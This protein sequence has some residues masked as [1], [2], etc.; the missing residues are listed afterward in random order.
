[1]RNLVEIF[2][3]IVLYSFTFSATAGSMLCW[4]D[5]SQKNDSQQ[6]PTDLMDKGCNH[7]NQSEETSNDCCKNMNACNGSTMFVLSSPLVSIQIFQQAVQFSKNE[8]IVHNTNSP[9]IPPPK[10]IN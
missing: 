6:T 7:N 10:L 8:H 1:M 9:P 3:I 4:C 5:M 2:C